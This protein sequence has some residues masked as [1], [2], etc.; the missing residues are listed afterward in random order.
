MTLLP[1]RGI[2]LATLIIPMFNSDAMLVPWCSYK[3]WAYLAHDLE[4]P[5]TYHAVPAGQ[6]SPLE[7]R[8]PKRGPLNA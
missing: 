8:G 7:R 5:I 2:C 6:P 3:W 1:P 4:V